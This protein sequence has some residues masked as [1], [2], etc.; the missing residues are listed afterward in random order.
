MRTSRELQAAQ[1]EWRREFSSE[2]F[3]S[4]GPRK[5]LGE[6]GAGGSTCQRAR[7]RQALVEGGNVISPSLK[8]KKGN[9]VVS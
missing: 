4:K 9:A 3:Q 6:E 7:L 2:D 8:E 1:G 5:N